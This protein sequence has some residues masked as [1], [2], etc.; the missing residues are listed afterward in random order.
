MIQ[1]LAASRLAQM[2]D[3]VI[4]EDLTFVRRVIAV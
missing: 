3:G 1:D 4:G 2:A